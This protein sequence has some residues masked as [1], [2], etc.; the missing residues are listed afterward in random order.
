MSATKP[1]ASSTFHS[2]PG[3]LTYA[4]A[5]IGQISHMNGELLKQLANIDLVHVPYKGAGLGDT[6]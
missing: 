1:L 3:A 6:E 4:S 2:V 5:G